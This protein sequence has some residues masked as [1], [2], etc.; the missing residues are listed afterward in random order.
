MHAQS[1]PEGTQGTELV[2]K[3]ASKSS[4]KQEANAL[5]PNVK[6]K[7]KEGRKKGRKERR[8]KEKKANNIQKVYMRMMSSN[9]H[10]FT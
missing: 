10:I 7:K 8:K 3:Q 1:N 6:Q 5:V 4:S 2:I 9:D